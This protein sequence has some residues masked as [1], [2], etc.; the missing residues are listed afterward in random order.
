LANIVIKDRSILK[1]NEE[2]LKQVTAS[3]NVKNNKTE[4][5][6]IEEYNKMDYMAK[7]KARVEFVN[8]NVLF[9]M[10]GMEFFEYKELQPDEVPG[11][12]LDDPRPRI[13][14]NVVSQFGVPAQ[15]I[16]SANQ[17]RTLFELNMIES[18]VCK[19]QRWDLY[20]GFTNNNAK[21]NKDLNDSLTYKLD[22]MAWVSVATMIGAL[23]SDVWILDSKIKNAPTTNDLDLSNE[24]Q[25][26]LTKSLFESITEHFD[27]I[28][29][30]IRVVYLPA[31]R[32]HDL[33][34]WV[35]VSDSNT[36]AT[37][38]I[39]PEVQNQIWNNGMPGG[40]LMPPVVFSNMLEGEAEGS[41]YGYALT[42][43]APGYFFQKP[44]FHMTDEKD[45][46]IYHEAQS[47]ITA[48]FVAPK[49]RRMNI[50]RFKI[51]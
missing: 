13:P 12:E 50:L 31:A 47:F 37:E 24:C 10:L 21:L 39:T 41:I 6:K 44:A 20:Q 2:M 19:T 14:V 38:T 36:P 49:Y 23:D 34:R 42:N 5:Q 22:D 26:R 29:R 27:K 15:V 43:E 11:Y 32:K 3:I 4:Q 18:A 1:C 8:K 25:G 35:S 9:N 46:G 51:G 17:S 40:Y 30:P 33:F 7:A 45:V 48:S 28:G 16:W